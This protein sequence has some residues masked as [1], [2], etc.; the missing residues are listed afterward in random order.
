[1]D[2]DGGKTG[3]IEIVELE[4]EKLIPTDW[5]PNELGEGKFNALFDNISENGVLEPFVVSPLDDGTYTVVGGHHRLEVCK[6]LKLPSVPCVIKYGM[7]EE[8]I[9]FQNLKLNVIRGKINPEKFTALYEEMAKAN[10]EKDIAAEM[11]ITDKGELDKMLV[12]TKKSLPSEMQDAFDKAKQ[13]IKTVDDLV[14]VL[15]KLFSEQGSQYDS[16]HYMVLNYEGKESIY[17]RLPNDDYKY[18]KSC[19]NKCFVHSIALDQ[20]VRKLLAYA[21]VQPEEWWDSMQTTVFPEEAQN[22]IP[23][24][25]NLK[26]LKDEL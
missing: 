24:E 15:N 3:K 13:N 9:K 14:L 16:T 7:T 17:I 11:G 6:I 19:A 2:V 26:G 20:V 12:Q 1:M 21:V 22:K 10:P 23:T 18:L 8:Q 4:L 5:N 25:D